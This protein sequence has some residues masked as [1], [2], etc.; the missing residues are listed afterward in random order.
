MP[1]RPDTLVAVMVIGPVVLFA[2]MPLLLPVFACTVPASMVSDR[3]LPVTMAQVVRIDTAPGPKL[4][5]PIAVPY[6]VPLLTEV[7]PPGRA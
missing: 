2:M 3:P 6:P 5:A 1:Y 7:A 4:F